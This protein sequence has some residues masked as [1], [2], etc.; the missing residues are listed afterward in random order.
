[1]IKFEEGESKF[2]DILSISTDF[3]VKNMIL[4]KQRLFMVEKATL[5]P[6]T[7]NGVE[8]G[9][10]IHSPYSI[11]MNEKLISHQIMK[12]TYIHNTVNHQKLFIDPDTNAN[13]QGIECQ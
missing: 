13:T 9:P 11:V 10:I 8:L 5:L 12:D 1:M 7:K 6:I 3:V 4:L 2:I